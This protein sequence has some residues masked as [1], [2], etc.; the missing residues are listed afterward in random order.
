MSCVYLHIATR[1]PAGL[2][3]VGG[4]ARSVGVQ[5]PQHR[6]F[7]TPLTRNALTLRH[8]HRRLVVVAIVDLI[9]HRF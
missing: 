3:A 5:Y 8:R 6:R 9:L 1:T 4:R 2:R 7:C